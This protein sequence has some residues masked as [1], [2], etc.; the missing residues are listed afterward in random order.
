M[1]RDKFLILAVVITAGLAALSASVGAQT[2]DHI[3][4]GMADHA[5]SGP[6]DAD[7]M[8]HMELTPV[9]AATHADSAKARAL[10]S[11]LRTA[12]AKYRDTTAAV[13]AGY[14]MFLPNIKDQRV[15]HFT[16]YRRALKEVFRFNAAE[17]TSLLY[18]K[19]KDGRL[20]LLGAMYSLPK[21]AKL[22]RLDDRVPLSIAQWHRHVNWCLPKKGEQSRFKE[23]LNHKPKFGPESPIAT[24]AECDA[25]GGDFHKNLFGWMVHANVFAG[26]DLGSIFGDSHDS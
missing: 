15:Y 1:S 14:Q 13:A 5:M 18:R 11:E 7:M 10:V 21:G 25:A 23:T 12:I 19:G 26:D 24:R 22:S 16:N 6:M 4:T 9:R 2:P 8:K 20:E 3:H 17:P